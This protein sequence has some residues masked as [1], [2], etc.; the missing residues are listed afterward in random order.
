MTY[1]MTKKSKFTYKELKEKAIQTEHIHIQKNKT[2]KH[3]Q[4][5]GKHMF[6][7]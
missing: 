6:K 4:Q 2:N 5:K 3:K 7:D 1:T